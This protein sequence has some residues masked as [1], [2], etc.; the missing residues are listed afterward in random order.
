MDIGPVIAS[1]VWGTFNLSA[2]KAKIRSCNRRVHSFLF[3][4]NEANGDLAYLQGVVLKWVRHDRSDAATYSISK[5]VNF[6]FIRSDTADCRSAC[7][8]GRFLYGPRP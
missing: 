6:K 7:P 4:D 3:E 8:V 5:Y 2:A 1:A